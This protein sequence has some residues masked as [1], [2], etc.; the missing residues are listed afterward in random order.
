MPKTL[1]AKKKGDIPSVQGR[2]SGKS[3]GRE[4]RQLKEKS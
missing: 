2:K 1:R 4:G 3:P